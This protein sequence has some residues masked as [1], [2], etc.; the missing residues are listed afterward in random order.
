MLFFT[1]GRTTYFF[2]LVACSDLGW[3]KI[4]LRGLT[5]RIRNT[6]YVIDPLT[7]LR[8]RIRIHLFLGLLDPD[9]DP[10]V[11]GMDPDASIIKQKKCF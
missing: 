7:V 11:R 8:I 3:G 9:P 1:G 2:P 4:R 6:A 5:S 10:L